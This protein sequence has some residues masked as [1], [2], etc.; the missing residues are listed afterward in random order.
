MHELGASSPVQHEMIG[1]IASDI[2]IDHLVSIGVK[3]YLNDLNEGDTTG[4]LVNDLSEALT[5]MKF[6]QPGDV[7]LVKAS[8]AEN[9]DRLSEEIIKELK[10]RELER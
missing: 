1:K 8:R 2:G 7:L 5:F 9:L 10:Q 4:H 6:I 3:E